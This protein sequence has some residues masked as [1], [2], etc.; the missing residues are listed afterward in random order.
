[1]ITTKKGVY[2]AYEFR[3]IFSK[4]TH[5]SIELIDY[6]V[7]RFFVCVSNENQKKAPTQLH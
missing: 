2:F 4:H 6:A 5:Y 1:M 7:D 3:E